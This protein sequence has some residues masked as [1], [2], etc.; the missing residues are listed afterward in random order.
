[1]IVAKSASRLLPRVVRP[2]A[3][4]CVPMIAFEP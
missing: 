2:T 4:V 1:M 3:R